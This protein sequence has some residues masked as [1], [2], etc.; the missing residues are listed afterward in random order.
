MKKLRISKIDRQDRVKCI[1]LAI[2]GAVVEFVSLLCFSS[3]ISGAVIVA[4]I[5]LAA[6]GAIGYF[7]T[8]R[9][10]MSALCTMGVP[11]IIIL[12]IALF[13]LPESIEGMLLVLSVGLGCLSSFLALI[14]LGGLLALA[15]RK[16]YVAI[17]RKR[18]GF[19]PADDLE[20]FDEKEEPTEEEC[21]KVYRT[22]LTVYPLFAIGILFINFFVFLL[23][24]ERAIEPLEPGGWFSQTLELALINF[25][26]TVLF[27]VLAIAIKLIFK[28]KIKVSIL[29]LCALII[30]SLQTWGSFRAFDYGGILHSTIEEGGMFYQVCRLRNSTA[31]TERMISN[32]ETFTKIEAEAYGRGSNF[33]CG[34]SYVNREDEK[35]INVGSDYASKVE[36]FVLYLT[37]ASGVDP[38]DFDFSCSRLG[39]L[40][41]NFEL[42]S[43]VLDDG[44]IK[45]T[46]LTDFEYIEAGRRPWI[47][48][49][50]IIKE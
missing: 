27:L 5:L 2:F 41:D 47:S 33:S 17:H 1:L 20:D 15:G 16:I 46:V 24:I 45:L 19:D 21:K 22:K 50:W 18:Y 30:P 8:K 49:G 43:E 38:E 29:I 13:I 42:S 12:C 23:S 6:S 36:Y 37:P 3:G 25:V 39:N 35:E 32:D 14:I 9:V 34:L 44:R 31:R 26:I 11:V 48:I 4:V 28:K 7:A 10:I 40:N